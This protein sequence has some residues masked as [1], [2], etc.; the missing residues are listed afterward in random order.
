MWL[1]VVV[2]TGSGAN[3]LVLFVVVSI[4]CGANLL[5]D[6]EVVSTGSTLNRRVGGGVAMV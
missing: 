1:L 6:F 5:D 4:G 2:S 3:F